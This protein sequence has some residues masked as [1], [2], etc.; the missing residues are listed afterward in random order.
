MALIRIV[1]KAVTGDV[2]KRSFLN[3]A[4]SLK[5]IEPLFED[6][7]YIYYP[8]L[9]YD[10]SLK[11]VLEV[12][13]E[14]F[15]GF[16][17]HLI[18][19]GAREV[20]LNG[21]CLRYVIDGSDEAALICNE[22]GLWIAHRLNLRGVEDGL[23]VRVLYREVKYEKPPLIEEPTTTEGL[24]MW[25]IITCELPLTAVA[26]V[27]SVKNYW[28]CNAELPNE[29]D[30]VLE[31]VKEGLLG[32]SG[33]V[34][35]TTDGAIGYL[36]NLG[37]LIEIEYVGEGVYVSIND[38]KGVLIGLNLGGGLIK[39]SRLNLNDIRRL[40]LGL[41]LTKLYTCDIYSW[42][43]YML[44]KGLLNMDKLLLY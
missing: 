7:I 27:Y 10:E 40:G 5:S 11:D 24:Q 8:F 32:G 4:A 33:V 29:L 25:Y 17:R 43:G 44:A 3:K 36:A 38:A 39:V 18:S 28:C 19:H 15:E 34:L 21:R 30:L 6:D 14:D 42:Y 37:Y 9:K 1:F 12:Y 26:N 20:K 16:R 2:V 13:V 35:I 41:R 22:D 23:T 31:S